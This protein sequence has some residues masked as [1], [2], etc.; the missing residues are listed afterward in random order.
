M[1]RRARRRCAII[2]RNSLVLFESDVKSNTNVNLL[3]AGIQWRGLHEAGSSFLRQSVPIRC[4]WDAETS[5]ALQL[6]LEQAVVD[7]K[8]WFCGFAIVK[9]SDNRTHVWE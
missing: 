1:Q 8:R 7:T 4:S 9:V 3:A 6:I 5:C 2:H